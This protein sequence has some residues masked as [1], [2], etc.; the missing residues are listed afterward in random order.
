VIGTLVWDQIHVQ[1]PTTPPFEDWGG[2]AYALSALDA[3]LPEGWVA[4]P[5][6]KVGAD[7]EAEARSFIGG[8]SRIDD[9]ALRIVPEINNRVQLDYTSESRRVEQLTGGVPSWEPF[10][11]TDAIGTCDALYVNFISGF[12]MGLE[13]ARALRAAFAGPIYTD[14]H[15]LFL[16]SDDEGRRYPRRLDSADEWLRCS[17][18]IQVNEDEFALMSDGDDPWRV[19]ER[20][21]EDS[22]AMIVVT[23]GERGAAFVTGS[24]FKPDRT[25]W[26]VWDASTLPGRG[27]RRDVTLRTPPISGDPTGCG[28]VWGATMCASLL[29]GSGIEEA[30][31][32]ANRIASANVRQRGASGLIRYLAETG[33]SGTS[34]DMKS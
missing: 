21:S 8:L 20:L 2:I 32:E 19:T 14:L 25:R 13:G 10:E 6:L 22:C 7:V 15:S 16:A 11:I 12:E 4:R 17:D 33:V 29:G 28:D 26:P 3:T 23:L 24:G 30:M 34:R 5:I 1:D 27:V 31:S 18:V 9:A